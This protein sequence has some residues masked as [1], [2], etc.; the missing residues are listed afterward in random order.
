VIQ[1]FYAQEVSSLKEDV[2][3][4]WTGSRRS[5]RVKAKIPAHPSQA[6]D[7]LSRDSTVIPTEKR[8]FRQSHDARH[9]TL[10]SVG[11]ELILVGQDLTT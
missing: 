4:K 9:P 7:V 11:Q 5:R 3:R 10:F 6:L 8:S 1:G 2:N